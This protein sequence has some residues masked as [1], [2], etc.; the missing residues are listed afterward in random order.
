[1]WV[2]AEGLVWAGARSYPTA[3]VMVLALRLRDPRGFSEVK[4]GRFVVATGAIRPVQIDGV[5][6][7]ARAPW[8]S[9]VEG[10]GGV[11]LV[12]RFGERAYDWLGGGR[13]SQTFD[14]RATAGFS[15]LQRRTHGDISNHELGTDFGAAPSRWLDLAGRSAY[16]LS[17]PGIV[18]ASAS[19]SA[20]A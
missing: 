10:F 8:G 12:P 7:V 11:P 2:D 1:P 16:D 4:G 14:G 3:D 20:R 19:I 13:V 17:S 9:K 5:S 15:Y 18:D 6:G